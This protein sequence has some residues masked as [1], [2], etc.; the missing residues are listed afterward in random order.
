M[1]FEKKQLL[2]II[3]DN[4]LVRKGNSLINAKYPIMSVQEMRVI[5]LAA[6]QIKV[7]DF[8]FQTVLVPRDKVDG[9]MSYKELRTLADALMGRTVILKD[10]DTEY[11]AIQLVARCQIKKQS[12][13]FE[14]DFHPKMSEQLLELRKNF[15]RI[16]EWVLLS[17]PT[18]YSLRIYEILKGHR[19]IVMGIVKR[20]G[21]HP[22]YSVDAEEWSI[23]LRIELADFRDMLGINK[24]NGK[25]YFRWGNLNDRIL[26]KGQEHFK[27]YSDFI[28]EYEGGKDFG[29]SFTFITFILRKNKKPVQLD[30]FN[31]LEQ[32]E[33]GYK[34]LSA[35][36]V[37]LSPKDKPSQTF[38]IP[39]EL[40][41][42]IPNDQWNTS[43]GCKKIC[44][45]IFHA[46]GIESVQFYIDA[47]LKNKEIKSFGA[48]IRTA[49]ERKDKIVFEEEQRQTKT[50]QLETYRELSD[51]D[52][53]ELYLQKDPIA[54]QVWDAGRGAEIDA[55]QQAEREAKRKIEEEKE[56]Q[57]ESIVNILD[58]EFED[59]I[60]F[61]GSGKVK[62][63]K[64]DQW[65]KEYPKTKKIPF[66]IKMHF[67]SRLSEYITHKKREVSE[68]ELDEFVI[69]TLTDKLGSREAAEKHYY[70]KR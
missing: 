68:Q 39:Q 62:K 67:M 41:D 38:D 7:N 23:R 25:S 45:K 1:G 21:Y 43:K 52:L 65:I 46:E 36:D 6:A 70:S 18:F 44:E 22:S 55:R 49:W 53:E 54:I 15:T 29:R 64:F 66:G 50:R 30:L 40:I 61:T 27:S 13:F 47:A 19:D 59:F 20:D 56:K 10:S 28:Y 24:K 16:P 2:D 14:V 37:A 60:A 63:I 11:E 58:T 57:L 34:S 26:L 51:N 17:M 31:A 35:V 48:W 12:G 9:D 69:A 3:G 33:S 8:A 32:V 4:C 42:K 5:G